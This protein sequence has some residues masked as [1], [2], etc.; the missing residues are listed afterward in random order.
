MT[1]YDKDGYARIELKGGHT[2]IVSVIK[3]GVT[4][5]E[6]KSEEEDEA[7]YIRFREYR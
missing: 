4:L 1:V 2:D 3:D 6:A 7:R 5:F